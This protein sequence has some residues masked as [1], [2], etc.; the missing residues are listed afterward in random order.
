MLLISTSYRMKMKGRKFY[1]IMCAR[2]VKS[3]ENLDIPLN[4][5]IIKPQYRDTFLRVIIRVNHSFFFFFFFLN[6][7]L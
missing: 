3:Y 4:V 5:P 7:V 2:T 6:E 1:L